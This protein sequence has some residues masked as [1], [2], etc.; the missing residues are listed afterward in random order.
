MSAVA[1]ATGSVLL[2]PASASV[3]SMPRPLAASAIEAGFVVGLNSDRQVTVVD[4]RTVGTVVEVVGIALN[5]AEIG[6]PVTI[7]TSGDVTIGASA[8]MTPG[9][10]YYAGNTSDG[11]PGTLVPESDLGSGDYS[12]LVGFAVTDRKIRVQP[13]NASIAR[14]A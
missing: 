8:I 13:L 9:K 1:I 7:A 11:G 4:A 5:G 2:D 12:Q 10:P 3:H 14:T 6:Q